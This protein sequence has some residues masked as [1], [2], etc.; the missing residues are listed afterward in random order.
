MTQNPPQ[1]SE[2][3]IVDNSEADWKVLQYLKEWCALSESIDI[4]TGYFEI[5]SLLA[6]KD[7]WRKTDHIRLLMGDEVSL[8]TKKAFEAGIRVATTRLDE[9]LE[10]EKE[11]NDFLEGVPAI[12]EAIRSGRIAC[13]VYRKD[14][15]HAKAYITHARQRVVGSV[16]LVGSSNFTYPGL[17]ENIELN[18][19]ITGRQVVPLQE[20][21]DRHWADAEDVT[22]EILRVIER[23]ARDHTPFEVYAKALHEFFR[24]HEQT[25]EEWELSESVLYP[26]LSRYQRDGYHNLLS[27]AARHRGA[28]LCDGVGLGKTFIGLMLIERLVLRERKNVMLLVPKQAKED[29]WRPLLDRYLPH[30]AG[31]FSRLAVFSHTD[32]GREGEYPRHFEEMKQL[33]DVVIIDEAHHFRNPGIKGTG[34][35][36][37]SRYR[38]LEDLLAGPKGVKTLF[39]LTATPVNNSLDDFRH[40]TELFTGRTAEGRPVDDY[41]ARTLGINS[42]RAHFVDL[43][44]RLKAKTETAGEVETNLV[45]AEEVLASDAVFRNLVVQRS[46]AYVKRSQELDGAK[47]ALFP[48]REAPAVADYSIRKTYGRLLG[49]LEK[50]FK[51]EKPL[52]ALSLYYPYAYYR[53]ADESVEKKWTENRQK[54]VVSLIRTQFLKRFESSALA[55]ELSCQRLLK[56]LL[57]WAEKHS[58]TESRRRRHERWLD[59]HAET[60]GLARSRQIDWLADEEDEADEDFITDEMREAVEELNEKDFDIEAILADTYLDLAEIMKFI[61]ELQKF[62]PAQ[63]DKLKALVRLLKADKR[64][65]GRKVIVFTEFAETARYLKRRLVEEGLDGVEEIDSGT[66]KDRSEVIRRFAPYY[67]GSSSAKLKGEGLEEI[68]VLVST[69][70]LSEGL[71]LQDATFLVNYDLHWNPVRLM[72]RI[73]R[74]DRRMNPEVEAAIV[75]DHPD[76]ARLRGTIAFWNFLPPD[77]LDELLNLFSRVSHKTL[78]ISKTFGIE[79]RTLLRPDDAFDDLKEFNASYEGVETPVEALRLEYETLLKD[80][81]TLYERLRTLPGRIVSGRERV[82]EGARA[83]FFCYRI[84]RPDAT[85][86]VEDGAAAWTDEAGETQWFLY[87]LDSGRIAEEEIEMVPWIRSTPETPRVSRLERPLLAEIRAKVEKHIKNTVFRRLQAPVGVKPLLKCWMEL[88]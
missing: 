66:K 43:D 51:K 32:L 1:G 10:R 21:F 8:R 18:V 46:R 84:P 71:N 16:A 15:F 52:F 56:K 70:V 14:K 57:A 39:M 5:G 78:R 29:V 13:R 9:S 4:A 82:A 6:L 75:A 64:L 37:P 23:H 17:T 79:G 38:I 73:G 85:R 19:Q 88:S 53:G 69:D 55:F 20:W 11:K 28:F 7:E 48:T 60:L 34:E 49:M 41:F 24:G 72:Q 50:A 25:V 63:D 35:K 74:V 36:R 83:V 2:L 61:E 47:G 12:V 77:E 40:M 30:L 76:L 3:F 80:D 31:N 42:L 22:P 65:K 54:Q 59:Q 67:N 86:P 62:K 81:P 87:D 26:V 33:A 44:R 68:R 27:I 45:E 58:R